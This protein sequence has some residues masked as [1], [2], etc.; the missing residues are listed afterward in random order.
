MIVCYNEINK[1]A[2]MFICI[3]ISSLIS[4]LS[5]FAFFGDGAFMFG[6]PIGHNMFDLAF[7]INVVREEVFT[8]LLIIQASVMVF[9]VTALISGIRVNAKSGNNSRAIYIL[10]MSGFVCL[11]AGVLSFLSVSIVLEF[12]PGPYGPGLGPII[13]GSLSILAAI[14]KF[15]ALFLIRGAHTRARVPEPYEPI[16]PTKQPPSNNFEESVNSA[17]LEFKK[18]ELILKYKKMADEGIITPEEFEKK[19]NEL[20]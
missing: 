4:L 14:L 5:I 8:Y 11:V 2:F 13:F 6:Q 3:L 9:A 12:D 16:D 20:L 17:S 10:G 19:K 18:A 1:V 15:V 7:G